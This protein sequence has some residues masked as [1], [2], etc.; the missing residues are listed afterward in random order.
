MLSHWLETLLNNTVSFSAKSETLVNGTQVNYLDL[1]VIE[2]IPPNA[3]HAVVVSSGIHG[4]ETAPIELVDKIAKEIAQNTFLLS[5]RVLLI[6]AHQK[7][8]L[9]KTRMIE[10]NLNRLFGADEKEKNSE[11]ILANKLQ[12][13]VHS[14]FLKVPEN[15]KRWHFDLHCAIRSSC[16]SHFALI[17]ICTEFKDVTPLIHFLINA[18]IQAQL[19]S[20]TPSSTFSWWTGQYFNALSVTVELG[21]V[22]PLFKNDLSLLQSVKNALVTL[23]TAHDKMLIEFNQETFNKTQIA[24]YRVSRTITKLTDDFDFT[25]EPTLANFSWFKEGEVIAYEGNGHQYRIDKEGEA[26]IFPNK[27][28]EVGQRACLLIKPI[29]LDNDLPVI[30][31]L[32]PS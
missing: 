15:E 20:E 17:P 18:K 19:F 4:N 10:K 28:V 30:I 2:I 22:K 14:F 25:F 32:Y 13:Q 27:E 7:A 11:S 24:S 9:N 26:V 21:Q 31:P 12:N 23:M 29:H 5:T 16:Y 3:K 8:I 1:G 6:I